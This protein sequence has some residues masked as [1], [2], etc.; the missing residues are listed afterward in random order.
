MGLLQHFF[1]FHLGCNILFFLDYFRG[2]VTALQMER[3]WC[4]IFKY[5]MIHP[6]MYRN[7]LGCNFVLRFCYLNDSFFTG[8]TWRQDGCGGRLSVL[9][10]HHQALKPALHMGAINFLMI[11]KVKGTCEAVYSRYCPRGE[12]ALGPESVAFQSITAKR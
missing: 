3:K 8:R 1:S 5:V 2:Y 6:F 4:T 7:H 9:H 10:H 11:R 12:T